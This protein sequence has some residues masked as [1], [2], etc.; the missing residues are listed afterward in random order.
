M[1]V[2]ARLKMKNGVFILGVGGRTL[3]TI[4]ARNPFCVFFIL[5]C[6]W[7]LTPNQKQSKALTHSTQSSSKPPQAQRSL[8]TLKMLGKCS[9]QMCAT[10]L[11]EEPGMGNGWVCQCVPKGANHNSLRHVQPLLPKWLDSPSTQTSQLCLA[12]QLNQYLLE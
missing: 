8:S 5:L 1:A 7:K 12:H 3:V 4:T 10:V 2:S 11:E 6:A 9:P